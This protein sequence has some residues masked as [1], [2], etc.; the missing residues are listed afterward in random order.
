MNESVYHQLRETSWRRKL[1]PAEETRLQSWLAAHPDRQAEWDQE[2]VLT[3]QL[4][5]LTDAPLSSNFTAQVMQ[6]LDTE[7][8]RQDREGTGGYAW[9]NWLHKLTP[10]LAPVSL[11]LV[12]AITAF[13]QYRS[14]DQKERAIE[15]VGIVASA[16]DVPGPEI[17]QDFEA[18]EKLPVAT[19]EDLLAALQ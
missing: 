8:A 3:D 4:R 12:V 16:T 6:T 19:D 10:K 5:H 14:F 15:S 1:T 17:L 7:L 2:Q 9:L 11:A 13:V 18:I